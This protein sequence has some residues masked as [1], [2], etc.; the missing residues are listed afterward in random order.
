MVGHKRRARAA[1]WLMIIRSAAGTSSACCLG[2]LTSARHRIDGAR[3]LRIVVVENLRCRSET[4]SCRQHVIAQLSFGECAPLIELLRT[5]LEIRLV[6]GEFLQLPEECIRD[7]K[8]LID[9][10]VIELDRA[11]NLVLLKTGNASSRQLERER[12]GHI[13]QLSFGSTDQAGLDDFVRCDSAAAVNSTSGVCTALRTG[14][15]IS[16]ITLVGSETAG[17]VVVVAAVRIVTLN[18]AS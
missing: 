14:L 5:A 3:D 2:Q 9:E 6:S 8:I 16:L 11:L 7:R 13:A 12:E 18:Q 4:V 1:L 15:R 17:E 10:I